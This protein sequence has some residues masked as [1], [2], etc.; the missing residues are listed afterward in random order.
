MIVIFG[1]VSRREARDDSDL[2]LLVVFHKVESE[3]DLY[4]IIA[5]QFVGLK[6]PFDLVIM[7]YDDLLRYG[8]DAYS[9]THVILST[10][11]VIYVKRDS[12]RF[13]RCSRGSSSYGRFNRTV[14]PDC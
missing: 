8:Q 11:E 2:D 14:F 10:G 5:R 1:S 4:A 9:F 12:I 6:L 7:S 13:L 3:R